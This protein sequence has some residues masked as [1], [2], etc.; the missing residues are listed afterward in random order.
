MVAGS[1][2]AA[3]ATVFIISDSTA[4]PTITTTTAR[5][6][7]RPATRPS[8]VPKIRLAPVRSSP[9]V[10]MY[11]DRM[12][13]TAARLKP[14]NKS[15]AG[16]SRVSPSTTSTSSATRSGRIRSLISSRLAAR[17]RPRTKRMGR[18]ITRGL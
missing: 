3:A 15:S 4:A 16:T 6:S 9:A 5:A 18:V 14:A 17:T 11:S 10:M 13:M 7:L 12:V 2:T 1:S 8:C